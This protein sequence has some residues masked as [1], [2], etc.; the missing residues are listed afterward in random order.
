MSRR[1]VI[2]AM[3][4]RSSLGSSVQ[5]IYDRFT[6]GIVSMER[7]GFAPETAVSPIHDFDLKALTGRFKNSRYLNRGAQFSL[8]TALEAL[9]RSNLDQETLAK[10]GLYTGAG[11]N[12][13][14]GKEFPEI[15]SGNLDHEELQALWLLKFLPNTASSAITQFLGL[16]G[17]SLTIS[18]ACS[19]SLQAIGEAFRNIKHGSSD[20][21]F[22]G[23]GD[24]RINPGGILAYKKARALWTGDGNPEQDYI[25]FSK[26]RR[27]FIA[28]EGGAFFLLEELEHAQKRNAS[29]LCEIGGYGSSIDGYSMTA[30]APGGEWAEQ[31]AREALTEAGLVPEDIDL[32][33]THGTGTPRNDEMEA[34]LVHRVYGPGKP[35]VTALKSWIGHLSAACGAVELALVLACMEH[36]FI[37][38]IRNL[39]DPCHSEINF[40]S[41]PEQRSVKNCV[42]HNFGFGGQNA[43]LIIRRLGDGWPGSS[44]PLRHRMAGKK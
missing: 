21:V 18:T 40:V 42:L 30:P 26:E 9:G 3:G 14:I 27:G 12:L 22:A 25:P 39:R 44:A 4:V 7:P 38:P 37:P 20:L 17:N 43:V 1:V 33:S 31:A 10:A 32:V 15:N 5:E 2:T 8:A 29:I 6:S 16:H 11:P 23:G 19:A 34:E 36:N 13:D 24:S 41:A 28:G 35:S